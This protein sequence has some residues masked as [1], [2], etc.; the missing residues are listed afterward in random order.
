MTAR[1]IR[2]LP[3][4]PAETGAPSRIM[5]GQPVTATANQFIGGDGKFFCGVWTSTPGSWQVSYSEEEFCVILEGQAVLT[6]AEGT[7]SKVGPGD[8]FVIPAGFTGLWQT[9]TPLKKLY[10]ILDR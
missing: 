3:D 1:L 8:A 6:D 9:L 4:A 5:A 10:A 2:I 7:V